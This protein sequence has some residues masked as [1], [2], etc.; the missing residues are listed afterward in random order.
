[1]VD[2]TDYDTR[3]A[4]YALVVDERDRILLT[5]YIGGEHE[6]ACWSMPGGGVEF[7]E[8]VEQAVVREVMEETGYAVEVGGPITVHHVTRP[9]TGCAARPYK[10]VRVIFAAKVTGGSLG[11]TEVG[12]TT[13]F[14]QW[15]PLDQVPSLSPR[16][17]LIDIALGL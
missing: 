5:W 13:A 6:P 15:V 4:A 7:D 3:L 2:F 1:L 9:N 8:S 17:D 16:A 10:A 14:A 12:G 11:T